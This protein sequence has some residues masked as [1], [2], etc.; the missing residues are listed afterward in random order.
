MNLASYLLRDFAAL[1][2]R[3]HNCGVSIA[4][5]ISGQ[6]LHVGL[7]CVGLINARAFPP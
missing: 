2:S 3:R 4:R 1:E 5:S 6:W 7:G